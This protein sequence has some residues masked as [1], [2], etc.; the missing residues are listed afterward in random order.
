MEM[1][2]EKEDTNLTS[3]SSLRESLGTSCLELFNEISF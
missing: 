1:A 3:A 2:P